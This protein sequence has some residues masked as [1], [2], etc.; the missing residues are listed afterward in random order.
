MRWDWFR[1][2]HDFCTHRKTR[3][4]SWD[5]RG[6]IIAAWCIASR[7]PER[8]RLLI[9]AGVPADVVDVADEAKLPESFVVEALGTPERPGYLCPGWLHWDG[10]VLV[11]HDW[12]DRQ[13]G[14][15]SNEPGAA[16]E[17]KR[18]QRERTSSESH[19]HV[20]HMSRESHATEIDTEI[21]PDIET[22][23]GRNQCAPGG[24]PIGDITPAEKSDDGRGAQAFG[25][26]S[27][28]E[29]APAEKRP[30][31]G[32]RASEPGSG[33]PFE[34]EF[35]VWW[36]EYPRHINRAAALKAY[37]AR[38][39][40][41]M[42]TDELMAANRCHAAYHADRGTEMEFVP[43]ASTFLNGRVQEWVYGPP[44]GAGPPRPRGTGTPRA[45]STLDRII[46]GEGETQ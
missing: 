1:F 34:R 42:T 8:G 27:G 18:R 7:S 25:P 33:D 17:R 6:V 14:R 2:Y 43:H 26:G 28:G 23:R 19:A 44:P 36:A 29:T 10:D 22:E 40:G 3:R 39:R 38:R 12:V 41:G 21:E 11:V 37:R 32:A 45:F 5:Q 4:L 46:A 13:H 20:T 35:A 31:Q 15:P 9:A 30:E 24:A 16:A